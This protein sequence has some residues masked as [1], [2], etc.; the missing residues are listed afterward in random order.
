MRA[1]SDNEEY[2]KLLAKFNTGDNWPAEV[3]RIY[4]MSIWEYREYAESTS[5]ESDRRNKA[6]KKL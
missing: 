3:E 1:L 5:K 4:R 2:F 6:I